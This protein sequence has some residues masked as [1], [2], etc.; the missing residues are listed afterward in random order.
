M[1]NYKGAGIDDFGDAFVAKLTPTGTVSY[2]TY[3]GGTGDESCN[4]L[5][6]DSTGAVY[7]TGRT[8]SGN[9]PVTSGV[10][11]TTYSGAG[12][13]SFLYDGG[14]AFVAKLTPQGGLAYSTYAGG[15]SDDIGG[16]ITFDSAGNAYVAGFTLSTNFPAAGGF[17]TQFAGRSDSGFPNENGYI[18]FHAGDAFRIELNSAGQRV[19]ATYLGG[20]Q[21]EG[22]MTIALDSNGNVWI[23][24]STCSTNFPLQGAVQ[25]T[26][27]GRSSGLLQPISNMC[28]GFLS[29]FNSSLSQLTYSTFL[30]GN[31]D[32]LVSAIAIDGA[33]AVYATGLTMSTD[34]PVS[35]SAYQ[36]TFA[37]PSTLSSSR[38]GT[39]GDAFVTK[40]DPAGNR[41][42]YS[43]Y[44]GAG[45]DD[46]AGAIAVDSS[47][48]VFVAGMTKSGDFPHTSDALQSNI[49]GR[50][51]SEDIG[52]VFL[53]KLDAAGSKLLYSTYLGGNSADEL[54][55]LALLPNGTVYLTGGSR[56]TDFPTTA[57]L[58]R[59]NTRN[60][61]HDTF[62]AALTGL[63]SGPTIG[64]SNVASYEASAF[65]RARWWRSSS[66]IKVPRTW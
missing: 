48:N 8:T 11:Q 22:A 56:S 50:G 44:L 16:A 51:T 37:G 41:L 19:A 10:T 55:G 65:L 63:G 4:S 60:G 35:S 15:S 5:A 47:G 58:Q 2:L 20:S 40:L 54:G 62:V 6:A 39:F 52:D 59:T 45:D 32:D 9:F 3:L 33:G 13:N 61:R 30:G 36:K 25:T 27:K 42:V 64:I 14:D 31:R 38:A 46:M 57:G 49:G 66:T 24:G 28:E 23:G 53:T 43:T 34:F 1:P 21:D 7:L 12:G 26:L 17:Q 29:R 18:S